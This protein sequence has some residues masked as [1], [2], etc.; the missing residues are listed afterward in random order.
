MAIGFVLS[1]IVLVTDL[2]LGTHLKDVIMMTQYL[3]LFD[4]LSFAIALLFYRSVRSFLSRAFTTEPLKQWHSYL[5][6]IVAFVVIYVAQWVIIDLLKWEIAGSQIELFGLDQ[7]ELNGIHLFFLV[8][9]FVFTA[10]I[11]EEIL[12]RGIIFGF[13]KTRTAKFFALLLASLTFGL[14]HPGHILSAT[15]MGA[16][17]TLLYD[18]TKT[19]WMSI[20]LHMAWNSLATYSLLSFVM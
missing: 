7:M 12:F 16:V 15:V 20:L 19:L 4:A 14:L 17:F 6:L 3:S 18:K 8:I 2:L 5:F 11:L 10:P 13:L 1:L 9:A